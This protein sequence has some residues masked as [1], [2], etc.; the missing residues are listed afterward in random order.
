MRAVVLGPTG[1]AVA[2]FAGS[3]AADADGWWLVPAVLVVGYL[4]GLLVTLGEA[5]AVAG[6]GPKLLVAACA[7]RPGQPHR[8]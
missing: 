6:L 3:A 1:M 8:Q 2:T 4:S 7:D 5:A